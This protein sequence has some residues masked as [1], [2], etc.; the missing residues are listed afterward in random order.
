MPYLLGLHK[1]LFVYPASNTEWGTSLPT[2]YIVKHQQKLELISTRP[3][4]RSPIMQFLN[5][6]LE[7]ISSLAPAHSPSSLN[8]CRPAVRASGSWPPDACV[9]RPS[10]PLALGRLAPVSCGLWPA[11]LRLR[12]RPR[13]VCG[14]VRRQSSAVVGWGADVFADWNLEAAKRLNRLL[15]Y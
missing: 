5:L 3:P 6:N 4:A 8:G 9:L 1:A 13:L 11:R 10:V 14:L 2:G 7:L 12:L 15:V